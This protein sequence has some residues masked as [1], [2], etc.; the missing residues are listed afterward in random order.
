MLCMF[1]FV[2]VYVCSVVKRV[3]VFL[4]VV[5][6]VLLYGLFC[7]L[8]VCVCLIVCVLCGLP[9]VMLYGV[10]LNVFVFVCVPKCV[11]ACVCV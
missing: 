9:N 1:V 7:V 3:W 6:C 2:C 4:F 8:C 11:C 10:L 5:D